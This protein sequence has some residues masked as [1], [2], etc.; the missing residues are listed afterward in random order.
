MAHVNRLTWAAAP[1]AAVLFATQAP[2]RATLISTV[3]PAVAPAGQG[4]FEF[5]YGV[6]NSPASTVDIGEFDLDVAPAADLGSFTVPT[7]YLTLYT[8]GDPTISFESTAASTDV[9]PG[10]TD[11]FSFES[12]AGPAADPYAAVSYDDGE[13]D[14][15][16]T[17]GPTAVPEPASTALVAAGLLAVRRRRRA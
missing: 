12:A 16:T 11:T 15:G 5:T 7:G 6:T 13:A 8:P 17:L 14:T 4:E 3:I 10:A 1:V 2:A 9:T